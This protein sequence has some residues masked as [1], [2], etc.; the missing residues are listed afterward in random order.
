MPMADERA[1]S[2]QPVDKP[3][4]YTGDPEEIR[5]ALEAG[6]G[7]EKQVNYASDEGVL[8]PYTTEVGGREAVAVRRVNQQTRS[9]R[10]RAVDDDYNATPTVD[11]SKWA[12]HPNRYD[13]IGIDTKPLAKHRDKAERAA[14]AAAEKDVISDVKKRDPEH[15][16]STAGTFAPGS[17]TVTM[18]DD[19]D[20]KTQR[21][22]FDSGPALAHEIGHA[23]DKGVGEDADSESDWWASKRNELPGFH[24]TGFSQ[25]VL[26]LSKRMRGGLEGK[27]HERRNYR[28][29]RQEA[30]ADAIGAVILDPEAAR[31]EAPEFVSEFEELVTGTRFEPVVKGDAEPLGVL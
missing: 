24:S 30:A 25:E 2:K 18:R 5:D 31:R 7:Y 9:D 29:K 20:D 10:A 27:S 6:A 28:L 3:G 12:R 23:I 17:K 22:A 26:G 16:G 1:P 14:A 11:A 4:V 21:D 15:M 19:P 13:Y 8:S